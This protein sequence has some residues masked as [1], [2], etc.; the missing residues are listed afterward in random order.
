[1]LAACGG[2][3]IFAVLQIVTP[4]A[5]QWNDAAFNESLTFLTP[6]P[7]DQV[8]ASQLDVTAVVVSASGV[9][10]DTTRNGVDVQGRLDNGKLSLQLP[11]A[12]SACLEGSFVNLIQ[13]DAV[14]QGAVP[15]HSY[16]NTRVDVRLPT[17]LWSTVNGG[18][19]LKFELPFT[20]DNNATASATGCDVSSTTPV[21]FTGTL[22][23]FDT[24]S[25]TRPL[26]PELRNAS[27]N[28]LL[29]RQVEFVDGATVTLI[30]AAGQSLTLKRQAD[31]ANTT[32][33]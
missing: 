16:L 23:G 27:T 2:G 17:G 7:D 8:F 1:V 9:C 21:R 32:C 14:V 3:E 19:K 22:Q 25:G 12:T 30:T 28:A 10:G 6:P 4:L 18:L 11:G 15:A 26:A 24:M 13:F 20:V 29:F 5:G 31:P 33:S